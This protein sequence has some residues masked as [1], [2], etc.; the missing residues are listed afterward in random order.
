[1]DKIKEKRIYKIEELE[2]IEINT[3]YNAVI[4]LG[5]R[6]EMLEHKY[7]EMKANFKKMSYYNELDRRLKRLEVIEIKRMLD[8]K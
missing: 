7:N 3:L 1:M 4:D 6:V 2:K 5:S 8:N